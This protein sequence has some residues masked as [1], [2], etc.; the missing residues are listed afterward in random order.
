MILEEGDLRFNFPDALAENTFK[1]DQQIPLQPNYLDIPGMPRV[2]FVVELPNAIYLIEVKD[3]GHPNARRENLVGFFTDMQNGT[4]DT[5]LFRK[6][7]HS[8]FFRW[9]EDKLHKDVHYLCLITLDDAMTVYLTDQLSIHLEHL[10]HRSTRWINHPIAN[11]QVFN[12]NNWNSIYP[13][14]TVERISEI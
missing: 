14:W 2:D 7:W 3:P 4:L 9:A 5:S 10:M 13:N 12:I 1:F 8:F 11:C 6:Y